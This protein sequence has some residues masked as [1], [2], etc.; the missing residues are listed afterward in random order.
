MKTTTL[1][2]SLL[3]LLGAALLGSCD[4]THADA[5]ALMDT[6][7]RQYADGQYPQALQNIDSLRKQF[8]QEIELRKEALKVYQD[9]ALKMAQRNLEKADSA[10]QRLEKEYADI[11]ADVDSKKAQGIATAEQL[12]R[13]TSKK[14]ELD[15]VK[16][17]FDAEV[18]R[19]KF[20]HK[21]QAEH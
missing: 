11:K 5:Q 9:A 18:A 1:I 2:P 3:F 17:R 12:T 16:A 8:P 21:K 10:L 4:H 6:I 7:R 15:S 14:M 20:I 13:A 19:V